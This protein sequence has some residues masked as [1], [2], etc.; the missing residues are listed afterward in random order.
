MESMPN[1]CISFTYCFQNMRKRSGRENERPISIRYL[2][3]V[4]SQLYSIISILV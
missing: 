2:P 3:K 4:Y 1:C